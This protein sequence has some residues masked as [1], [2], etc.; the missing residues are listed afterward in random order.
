[1][2][3]R[4][5]GGIV[6]PAGDAPS[7]T[8]PRKPRA[9][10]WDVPRRQFTDSGATE[11]RR[12]R[13]ESSGMLIQSH[14]DES[15]RPPQTRR[16]VARHALCRDCA[17]PVPRFFRARWSGFLLTRF[18]RLRANSPEEIPGRGWSLSASTLAEMIRVSAARRVFVPRGEGVRQG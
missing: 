17:F 13:D 15:A 16:R 14:A 5:S 6:V 1:M 11:A 3:Q 7:E 9:H 12:K 8:S 18:S 4:R 10:E 2:K